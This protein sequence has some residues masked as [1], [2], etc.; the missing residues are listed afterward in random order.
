M[1]TVSDPFPLT[2]IFIYENF[3]R[4]MDKTDQGIQI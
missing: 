1:F 2:E 4:F 3:G